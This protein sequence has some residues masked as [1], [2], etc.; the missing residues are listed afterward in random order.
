M[1]EDR[2]I[3]HD[4]TKRYNSVT[5]NTCST[6]QTSV[7]FWQYIY[8]LN[9]KKIIWIDRPGLWTISPAWR[10]DLSSQYPAPQP[11]LRHTRLRSMEDYCWAHNRDTRLHLSQVPLKFIYRQSP[12]RVWQ[13]SHPLDAMCNKTNSSENNTIFLI[14]RVRSATEQARNCLFWPLDAKWKQLSSRNKVSIA[15]KTS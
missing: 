6:D 13:T 8:R 3:R 5:A 10:S 14:L 7:K 12:T 1:I 15:G 11:Q 4:W 9:E 2:R